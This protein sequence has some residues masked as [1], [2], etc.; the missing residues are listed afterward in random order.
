MLSLLIET[1]T[2]RGI[3]SILESDRVRFHRAL[4]YGLNSSKY[5]LSAINEGLTLLGLTATNLSFVAAGVGPG[6]FTGIRVAVAT[7][8]AIGYA[9]KI[10]IIGI[11]TLEC[12]A[13][14]NDGP[15]AVCIDAKMGGVYYVTGVKLEG[16]I[17][18][19]SKPAILPIEKICD[20][21][22]SITTIVTPNS[23]M[24][25]PKIEK[26]CGEGHWEWQEL[27]PDP[28]LMGKIANEKL[29]WGQSSKNSTLE[30]LYLRKSQAEETKKTGN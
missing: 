22:E 17:F 29:M 16:N 26:F 8:Q 12:F 5:M 19:V 2:E 4:P 27:A 28:C 21:I 11:S 14:I 9:V 3:V 24:L 1:A 15:F 30:L 18:D 23:S 13:P 10:P 20:K 25:R 6:S 7:A